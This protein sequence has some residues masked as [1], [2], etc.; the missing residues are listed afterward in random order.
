M[1]LKSNVVVF[2]L[3]RYCP[4]S[5]A[6]MTIIRCAPLFLETGLTRVDYYKTINYFY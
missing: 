4:G 1:I 3:T 6:Q 2:F 5:A